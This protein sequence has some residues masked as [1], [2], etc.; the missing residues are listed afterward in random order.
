MSFFGCLGYELDLKQLLP[1]EEKQI[2]AQT[3]FYKKYRK[4]FQFG[5][6]RRTKTGWQ[7]SDGTVTLAGVFHRLVHAAPGYERLRVE[8][9]EKDKVYKVTSLDQALR[10][11]QFG[12]LVKHVA[13]VDLDPNGFVL[14]TVDRRFTMQSGKEDLTLSGAALMSG[15]LLQPT[16]RG[17]GYDHSQ[18]THGDF[19]SDIYI[20]EPAE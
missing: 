9:L 5:C 6:F 17:T 3:E 16:F 12:A 19:G 7:V 11:G 8:G 20:I 4:V 13:P 1:V 10:I 2:I 14:R 18:R 15:I